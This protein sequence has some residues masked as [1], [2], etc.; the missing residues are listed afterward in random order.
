MV[1]NIKPIV[2]FA[3]YRALAEYKVNGPTDHYSALIAQSFSLY[4]HTKE[5]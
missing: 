5:S 4:H 2:Y 1:S 3:L